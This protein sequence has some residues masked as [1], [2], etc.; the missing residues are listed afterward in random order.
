MSRSEA[1]SL[2]FGKDQRFNPPNVDL[3]WLDTHYPGKQ[4][5]GQ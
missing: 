5:F 3:D 4:Q 2:G 1:A